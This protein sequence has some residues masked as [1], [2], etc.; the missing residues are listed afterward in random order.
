ME[1]AINLT[2]D[3]WTK[4][5]NNKEVGRLL[6]KLQWQTPY[7]DEEIIEA[8]DKVFFIGVQIGMTLQECV[9]L[10]VANETMVLR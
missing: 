7:T 10:I 4:K 8:I 5:Y 3:E 6:N 2:I 9:E 1:E